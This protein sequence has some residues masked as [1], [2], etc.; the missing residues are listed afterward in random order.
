MSVVIDYQ[1][2]LLNNS[3]TL[4]SQ[5]DTLTSLIKNSGF[6]YVLSGKP[7]QMYANGRECLST[8]S[9]MT[10]SVNES[11][12]LMEHPVE[13]GAK[14]VDHKVFNPVQITVTI[15]FTEENYAAEYTEL[16]SLFTDC[17][18]ISMKTKA[19]VFENLQIVGIPHEEKPENINRMLFTIQL[20]EAI[21]VSASY[22]GAL[23]AVSS[24]M[25]SSTAKLGKKNT[26]SSM[27]GDALSWLGWSV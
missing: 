12:Q 14:I 22:S 3:Q 1:S 8:A 6:G 20:K 25:N 7:V 11:A 9:L 27:I 17:T 26:E 16:K 21:I 19:N 5:S 10:C 2:L 13:D 24:L 23:S 18:F 15:A 4:L